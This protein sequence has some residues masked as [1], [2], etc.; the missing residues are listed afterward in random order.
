[1]FLLDCPG[2]PPTFTATFT[3]PGNAVPAGYNFQ[4]CAGTGVVEAVLPHCQMFYRSQEEDAMVTVT[5][6]QFYLQKRSDNNSNNHG[7]IFNSFLPL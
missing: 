7:F 2:Y 3:I 5:P 6:R 4:V 1:M